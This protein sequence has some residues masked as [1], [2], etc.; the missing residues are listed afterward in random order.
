MSRRHKRRDRLT[1]AQKAVF[2]DL[3]R[4][5]ARDTADYQRDLRPFHASYNAIAA[6][7]EAIR[8][9][10]AALDIEW[11]EPALPPAHSQLPLAPG[12]TE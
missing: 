8:A 4:R 2:L 3:S 5:Y 6:L 10:C 12:A 1:D 7:H 11:P 9:A